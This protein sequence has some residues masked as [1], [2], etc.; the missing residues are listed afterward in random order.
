MRSLI[1]VILGIVTVIVY[2]NC[3]NAGFN[4]AQTSS[5]NSQRSTDLTVE[6]CSGGVCD[7]YEEGTASCQFGSQT[8]SHGQ[9]ITAYLQSGG[10]SC[11]SE[12][13]TCRN[14]ALSGSFLYSSCQTTGLRACLFNGETIPHGSS[15]TAFLNSSQSCTSEQRRCNDGV[16]SGSY[17]FASCAENRPRSCLF[18]NRTLA[19][20]EGVVAFL[21]TSV[22]PGMQCETQLRV[23]QDGFLSGSYSFSQCEVNVPRSCIFNGQTIPH[24][25]TVQAFQNSVAS[26]GGRCVMESRLCS[27]GV[28]SGTFN[29]SSCTNVPQTASC[30]FN[31]MTVPHG[32]SVTAFL[33]STVPFGS[34]SGCISENRFCT[35]GMLSGSY[36]FANC[37]SQMPRSCIFNDRTLAHGESVVAFASNSVSAGESCRAEMRACQNGILS[38]SF[39]FPNCSAQVLQSCVF[40]NRS[41]AHGETVMAFMTSSVDFGQNCQNQARTCNNGVLSGSAQFPSCVMSQP[42]S[43]MF[44]G[45]MVPHGGAITAYFHIGGAGCP[46]ESRRCEN[47]NL[48]GSATFNSCSD[49]DIPAGCVRV[50]ALGESS[51]THY[52]DCS[53]AE[54]GGRDGRGGTGDSDPG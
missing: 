14:G 19:S 28:L 46:S 11:D 29:F 22:S 4:A 44:N 8:L 54:G 9:S 23:C 32:S 47:G 2:Q 39:M 38:G 50:E 35:N 17:Q 41:V 12:S 7:G 43:C 52:I 26:N 21:S 33:N 51:K 18:D 42:R 36:M 10:G 48:S 16:L 25:G 3:S 53:G 13:R 45:Q 40:N 30:T 34:N 37:S 6:D 15:V 20:G 5:I 24:M 27:D 1:F 31:G 49:P